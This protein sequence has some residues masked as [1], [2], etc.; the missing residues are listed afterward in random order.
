VLPFVA[1]VC[2][3]FPHRRQSDQTVQ[4]KMAKR[5]CDRSLR[6]RVRMRFRS[7]FVVAAGVPRVY[8]IGFSLFLVVR[9]RNILLPPYSPLQPLHHPSSLAKSL[10]IQ[11]PVLT[12][13]ED[14]NARAWPS[15]VA[16]RGAP[17]CAGFLFSRSVNPRTAATFLFDSRER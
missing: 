13:R 14:S 15:M 9:F 12:D 2:R 6:A 5:H 1:D 10:P 4:E 17:R 8:G 7:I 3:K 16:V 11:R